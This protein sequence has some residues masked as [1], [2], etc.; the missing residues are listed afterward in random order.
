[1]SNLILFLLKIFINAL[2]IITVYG[3]KMVVKIGFNY[4][5]FISQ[6]L[7]FNKVERLIYSFY[8][9]VTLFVPKLNYLISV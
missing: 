4:S 9:Y 7:I 1:M 8:T 3:S 5:L 2:Y 6:Y